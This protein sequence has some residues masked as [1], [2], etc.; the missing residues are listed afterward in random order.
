M[1]A[2]LLRRGLVRTRPS[3][4]GFTLLDA[5]MAIAL[6]ATISVM[7][8]PAIEILN[9]SFLL[10]QAQQLVASELQQSRLKAVTANRIVRVRFNCPG[11]GLFRRVE[12]IGTPS[13]PT[14]QD[15]ASNRCTES[16]YPYPPADTNVVTLPNH[17]GPVRRL[18]AQV[19]FGATQTLEFRP[20]GTVYGVASDGTSSPLGGTGK[21]ITVVKGTG[22]RS[23]TVNS[24]GKIESV[25]Q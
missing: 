15:V 4:D 21:A 1:A 2:C 17:D 8:V 16:S 24:Y 9:D 23:V 5:L 19:S 18:P 12:L 20:D 6:I 11:V 25:R 13:A 10:G 22:V 3:Q 7:A 14:S